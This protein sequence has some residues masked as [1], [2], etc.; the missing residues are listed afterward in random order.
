M[1]GSNSRP[2]VSEALYTYINRHAGTPEKQRKNPQKNIKHGCNN[3]LLHWVLRRSHYVET[4]IKRTH[5]VDILNVIQKVQDTVIHLEV[6]EE[7]W[8]ITQGSKRQAKWVWSPRTM[9]GLRLPDTG[10]PHAQHET[11]RSTPLGREQTK[12]Y[13]VSP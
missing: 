10:T 7:Q 9:S 12:E 6:D 1:P 8:K 4:R 13:L 3:I 5:D 11:Q 2:N